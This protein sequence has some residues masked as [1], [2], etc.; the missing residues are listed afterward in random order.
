MS[1]ND[2]STAF[3]SWGWIVLL[4][5]AALACYPLILRMFGVVVIPQN[6]IGVVD[7]KF[8]LMGKNR[9]LPEGQIIAL[10]GEAGVQADTLAPGIH[11]FYWPWQYRVKKEEFV[12]IPPGK[13][14]LV[15][16]TG[17]A[18]LSGGRVLGRSV[19]CGMFQ[20]A[21]AFLSHGGERG[22]QMGIIPPG[23]YRINREVFEVSTTGVLDIPNNQVGIVTTKEGKGLETGEIAGEIVKGHNSF[24]NPQIFVDNGGTKGLQ[25]QVLLAGRYFI[26]PNFASVEM[27]ELTEIPIAHVGVVIS[28]VGKEGVDT[29]GENFKHGNLVT[30]G[31]KGVWTTPLDPGKYPINPFTQKVELVPTAN[32]V[33]NWAND[34]TEAHKLDK[35]LS[36]ITVRSG[37]GFTFN[38]DVSQII[39][40]PRNTAPA[41]IARFGSVENLVTQVLEPIIGNYFRNA[42]QSSDVIDFLKERE[43][44]QQEARAKIA[45]ALEDL[46]VGAVDT[47]IGD[48]VPPSELM[49]T[50][51]DRKIAD[52]QRVTFETQ[53]LSQVERQNFEAAAANASTQASVVQAQREIE[54]AKSQ[55]AAAVE[56]ATGVA[57]SKTIN[58]K[59]DAEVTRLTGDAEAGKIKAIG[60][61]EAEV[62]KQKTEAVTP[63]NYAMIETARLLSASGK[64]LVPEI[65]SGGGSNGGSGGGMVDVLFAKFVQKELKNE[66]GHSPVTTPVTTK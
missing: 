14:G 54:I 57:N 30:K 53:R 21:R 31:E 58:A 8:V 65:V 9:T 32:V 35:D 4:V 37:D 50:L 59:A 12:T 62:M 34:K 18:P 28:Y 63:D 26:N 66:N 16:A 17:G 56:T 43:S 38:L 42:A 46:G 5:V 24:Q 36:T 2:I 25:E 64:S 61:S 3:F 39:H 20:D 45:A 11:Y 1:P 41:V 6:S 48:I 27:E 22:P 10:N 23:T 19:E 7:K 52:Q 15:E 60:Q 13:I 55:A 47:L 49:K 51:T 29:S 44:R 33:L 40:I